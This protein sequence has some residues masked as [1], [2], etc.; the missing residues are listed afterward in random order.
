MKPLVVRAFQENLLDD[1]FEHAPVLPPRFRRFEPAVLQ[2]VGTPN[3]LPAENFP[4][5]RRRYGQI[6]VCGITRQ[7]WSVWSYIMVPHPHSGGLFT[8][9]PIVMRKIPEPRICRLKHRYVDELAA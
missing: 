9:V 5:L 4:I 3:N 6:H 7:I 1:L 8:L 2:Q